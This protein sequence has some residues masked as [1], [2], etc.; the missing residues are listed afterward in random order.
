MSIPK[1]LMKERKR[2]PFCHYPFLEYEQ[3]ILHACNINY[4]NVFI[5]EEVYYN[6]FDYI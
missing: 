1:C 3:I 4:M 5:E 6:F 2:L